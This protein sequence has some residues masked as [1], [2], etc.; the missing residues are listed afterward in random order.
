MR[1]V[2]QHVPGPRPEELVDALRDAQ[3]Y[4]HSLGITGWQDA[5][6]TPA[7]LTAYRDLAQ[8][9]ELTARV[10]AALW[11]DR[12][13]G[14]EQ[15]EELH[16]LRTTSTFGRLRAGSVKMMLDGVAENFTAA[17]TVPYLD[18]HGRSSG[19]AGIS[20][21]DPQDLARHVVRLD[22]EGF[23]VHF[24][25]IGDRAVRDALDAVAAA[26]VANGRGDSRHHIAHVQIVHPD[27]LARFGELAVV[28]NIQPYWASAEPQMTELTI[29]FLGPERSALQYPFASLQRHGARLAVGSDWSVS[30]PDPL[31][32]VETAVNR[33]RPDHRDRLPFLP[34]ERLDLGAVITAYTAGSAYVNFLDRVSGTIEP[35]KLADLAVIDQDLFAPDAGPAADAQVILTMIGG[36]I[37]FEYPD[38]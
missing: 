30:P 12:H 32:V 35:G 15:I 23:Q 17:M 16:E 33:V 7:E 8:R 18:L 5:W 6:V 26:L 24:H 3:A 1:L 9:G 37:V 36:E 25:A 22:R 10:A 11:W 13:R 20:F 34:E 38:R 4:L 14:D 21:I 2:E 19:N 29:P 31:Q 28:A 27:D